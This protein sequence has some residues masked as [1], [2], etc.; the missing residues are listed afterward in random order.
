MPVRQPGAVA[1]FTNALVA[2][3][4][5]DRLA[6]VVRAIVPKHHVAPV[7][8]EEVVVRRAR[9]GRGRGLVEDRVAR[10]APE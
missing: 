6:P 8:E 9:V 4:E 1:T 10:Q 7:H 3:R 5:R 2:L